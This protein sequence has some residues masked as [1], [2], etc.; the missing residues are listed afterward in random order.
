MILQHLSLINFRNYPCLELDLMPGVSIFWGGNAQGKTNLL[1]AIYFL[2]TARPAGTTAER[3]LVNWSI[4][5]EK[6]SFCRLSA[7]VDDGGS[8]TRLEILLLLRGG[9]PPQVRR[10]VRVNGVVR[11][12]IE[13]V[14][15]LRTVMFSPRDIALIGGE[16][17]LRRRWL[18]ILNAQLSPRYFRSLL[19]YN[20]VLSQRNYLLKAIAAQRA[21][22]DELDFWD[23]ELVETGSYLTLQRQRVLQ[24]LA[25]VTREIHRELTG[26]REELELLYRP[27]ISPVGEPGDL[28]E[29][30]QVFRGSLEEGRK[31]E[32]AQ[33]VSLTGPHRDDLR[34]R[35]GGVDM[36]AYG[37]RGQQ[38][39]IALSLRL[40][41]ARFMRQETGKSPVL[42]LDDVL[43]ELDEERRGQLLKSVLDYRQVLITATELDRFP[44]DFLSRAARFKV[45]G[46]RVESLASATNS[47]Y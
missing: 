24:Q 10:V 13:L 43:S 28:Q 35:V 1:E 21:A 34:F 14:G 27:S 2:S 20:R 31:R 37:S 11:R 4:W 16:P 5:Q 32:I 15:R 40:G 26:G 44:A 18:D 6:T 42:L 39:T 17:L 30:K 36:G 41:E 3:D 19:H 29:I 23:R 25:P 12:A 7:R 22:P 45:E 38:R 33:G 8:Q 9:N 46:G 47:A